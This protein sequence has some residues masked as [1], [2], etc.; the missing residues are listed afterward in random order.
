MY[1]MHFKAIEFLILAGE[2]MCPNVGRGDIQVKLVQNSN[3]HTLPVMNFKWP[4]YITMSVLWM[5]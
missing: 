4:L 3:L 2:G 5:K 1:I